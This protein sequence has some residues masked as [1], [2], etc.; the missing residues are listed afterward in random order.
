MYILY[1]QSNRNNTYIH[2]YLYTSINIYLH[3]YIYTY[4]DIDIDII[5]NSY[6]HQYSLNTTQQKLRNFILLSSD[7]HLMLNNDIFNLYLY[8]LTYLFI[9]STFFI[10]CCPSIFLIICLVYLCFCYFLNFNTC[11]RMLC[12]CIL[13]ICSSFSN[14]MFCGNCVRISILQI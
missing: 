9:L 6:R 2:A 8:F 4:I 3:I 5:T 14:S 10:P 7:N 1:L 11:L 13:Y 12:D